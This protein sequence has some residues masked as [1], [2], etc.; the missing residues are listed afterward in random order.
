MVQ[1]LR[2]KRSANFILLLS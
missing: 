1:I 2:N